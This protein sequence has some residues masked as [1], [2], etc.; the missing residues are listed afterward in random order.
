MAYPFG[1]HPTFAHYLVWAA[2]QGCKI[3]QGATFASDGKAYSVTI[4]AASS[5]KWVVEVGT[6]HNDFLVPT[7][8]A[9]LDR[10]LGMESPF[11]SIDDSDS[12]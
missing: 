2:D 10:R 3:R 12:H 1:G 9:R 8:I 4:I 5:G 6:Q 11:F 7:T